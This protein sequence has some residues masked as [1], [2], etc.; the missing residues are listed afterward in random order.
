MA[1]VLLPLEQVDREEVADERPVEV[2]GTLEGLGRVERALAAD[3]IEPG[4]GPF[5]V[6]AEFQPFGAGLLTGREVHEASL[7]L[8]AGR[9]VGVVRHQ[10]LEP[11]ERLERGDERIGERAQARHRANLTATAA[12][13]PRMSRTHAVPNC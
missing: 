6:G 13:E 2:G 11:G 3:A 1:A 9:A 8:F 4:G 7:A 12:R 5:A 10:L